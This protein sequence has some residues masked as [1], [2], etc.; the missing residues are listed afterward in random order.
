MF[1][2]DIVAEATIAV[3]SVDIGEAVTMSNLLPL[4]SSPETLTSVLYWM[5]WVFLAT[6]LRKQGQDKSLQQHR[7]QVRHRLHSLDLPERQR[8]LPRQRRRLKRG[9]VSR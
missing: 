8:L 5:H 1:K 9:L 4:S 6:Q 7:L 3:P 2:E